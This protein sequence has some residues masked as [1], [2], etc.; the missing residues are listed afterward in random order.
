MRRLLVFITFVFFLFNA[1]VLFLFQ[2]LLARFNQNK[3]H[4]KSQLRLIAERLKES[5]IFLFVR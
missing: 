3:K 4:N 1:I 2:F 5:E